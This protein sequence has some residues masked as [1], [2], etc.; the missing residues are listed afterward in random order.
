MREANW[1]ESRAGLAGAKDTGRNSSGP[2]GGKEEN[3]AQESRCP[4]LSHTGG[5]LL[6]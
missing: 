2:Y 6:E 1:G 4:N 3:L 5:S